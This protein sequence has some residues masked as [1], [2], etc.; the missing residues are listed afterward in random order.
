MAYK[1][2]TPDSFE[3][4]ALKSSKRKKNSISAIFYLFEYIIR[5]PSLKRIQTRSVSYSKKCLN[6]DIVLKTIVGASKTFSAIL[7]FT[8]ALIR[9]LVI[10][11]HP[12]KVPA[13]HL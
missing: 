11:E 2:K 6:F 13:N 4:G 10:M 1:Q 5:E 12:C 8:N 7:P 9:S 3:P